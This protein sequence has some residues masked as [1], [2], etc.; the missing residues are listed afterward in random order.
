MARNTSQL[1]VSFLVDSR[2]LSSG[3]QRASRET[4][5][6]ARNTERSSRATAALGATLRRAA[7][8]AGGA[9]AAYLSITQA[10]RAITTTQELA[11]T[12]AGLNR[13]LGLATK[14]ASRWA[15][16]TR[17]RGVDSKTLIMSFT[18]LSRAIDG[19][20][21]GSEAARRPFD[22]LGISQQELAATSG[23][24]RDQILLVADALGDAEGSSQRQA[25]AAK[26]LGRGYRDIL[27]LFTEG[28]KGLQEQLR[29]ADEFGAAMGDRTV[30]AMGDF[31]TAQRR[32]RVAV[33]GLQIAFA[34]FATPAITEAI[35]GLGQLAAVLNSPDLSKAEKLARLREEFGRLQDRV[36]SLINDLVPIVAQSAGEIGVALAKGIGKGFLETGLLG[37]VAISALV[38]RS[39]GGIAGI[40]AAGA[41]VGGA[42]SQGVNAGMLGA[43]IGAGKDTYQNFS[44]GTQAVSKTKAAVAGLGVAA[45]S[46]GSAMK[47]LGT[48]VGIVA[49]AMLSFQAATDAIKVFGSDAKDLNGYLDQTISR[50]GTL[51]ARMGDLANLLANIPNPFTSLSRS[52][53]IT[54][55]SREGDA[56]KELKSALEEIGNADRS[57][58]RNLRTVIRQ[59]MDELGVTGRIRREIEKIIGLSKIGR[60]NAAG[61]AITQMNRTIASGAFVGGDLE[62]AVEQQL[63]RINDTYGRYTP[64]WRAQVEATFRAQIDATRRTYTEAGRLTEEGQR[65]IQAIIRNRARLMASGD[66]IGIARGIVNGWRRAGRVNESGIRS[67]IGRLAKMPP[68]ARKQAGATMIAYARE[69]EQKGKLPDGTVKRLRSRLILRFGPQLWRS[70]QT[71]TAQGWK[72]VDNSFD[73]GAEDAG[74][75]LGRLERRT[76]EHA[77]RVSRNISGI[78]PPVRA[79]YSRL[80]GYANDTAAAFGSNQRVNLSFRGGG[81]VPGRNLVPAA[82]SPGELISHKGR[83]I[84]VPGK[85]EPRDSVLM[86]LPVGAKVFTRDGQ[87]RL[88]AGASESEALRKQ[89]P[90]FAAGGMVGSDLP[91]PRLSGGPRV[92]RATG[93]AAIDRGR[94]QAKAWIERLKPTLEG[95][96]R[97]ASKFGLQT[98]SGY[99]PGDDGYHGINRARDFSNS[100]GPTPEMLSFAKYVGGNFGRHLLE[101]IYSPLGWSIKN[102]A[103]TAPYA[104]ADHYDHVHV[105][106][107]KG[108]KVGN[109]NRIYPESN[110]AYGNWGG[111]TLPSYV[112][113]ALAQAAG[114]PGKTMEQVT[115]GESGAHR[116]NSAR[117]GATGIDPG[118]TKGHGLWMITSGYNEDL[119]AKAGG[120]RNMLNPVVNAWA[121]AQIYRRQGLGAWYGTGSVTGDGLNYTGKY[122]IRNALGGL[123]FQGALYRATN[124]RLG[125]KPKSIPKIKK[126]ARGLDRQTDRLA[127]NAGPGARRALAK[128]DRLAARAMAAADRGDV[129]KAR[130]LME[131]A[132]AIVA[133][134]SRSS[135]GGGGGGGNTPPASTPPGTPASTAGVSARIKKLVQQ[136]KGKGLGFDTRESLLSS[137]LSI[138]QTTETTDDDRFVLEAQRSL[139]QGRLGR[140]QNQLEKANR[141]LAKPG[142][143]KK[144]RKKWQAVRNNALQTLGMAQSEIASINSELG[145]LGAG[146][147]SATDLAEAMKELAEAIQEQN[148]LQSS[149]QATSSREALRMLSDVISGQIVGKRTPVGQ[150]PIGVRY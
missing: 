46:A 88:A 53:G 131:Q 39:F 93:Q 18:S 107:R 135:G 26:L 139:Q 120:W 130:S 32:G 89:A 51:Q 91:R 80:A 72:G 79:A 12:T 114:M 69:L 61:D 68:A 99:R 123:S 38:V 95:L 111:P 119:A 98:T 97:L 113:A 75:K 125:K 45:M 129:T 57:R 44:R 87:M 94:T 3:F 101:L 64:R 2:G 132:R 112:V 121:A 102:G 30:D 71:A 21:T 15:A 23:S 100:S 7:L 13:N 136:S 16:V 115:R 73:K 29:W 35:E 1:R 140:A 124:G 34:K 19:V 36:I 52:I 110:S 31:T 40:R 37:K 59:R 104:V 150:T 63:S 58:F 25:A 137:A 147:E 54:G 146:G 106:L 84:Y 70:I 5:K 92:P 149:V 74:N 56:A 133:R 77:R 134:V 81:K 108:G 22:S 148:R 50:G 33:M 55:L 118:G 142:L 109:I 11:L 60:Q 9:A 126:G 78:N 8:A 14:E 128:A 20:K 85:P 82:V 122:D 10:Q 4:D 76:R 65:R 96:E 28:S 48:Q 127:A 138:A 116:K 24:F 90:H 144:E 83:E 86:F 66:P 141:M 117:P 105:A 67:F 43:S 41:T 143:S 42:L 27:P 103:R 145:D 17:A 49:A 62:R 6:F 47:G